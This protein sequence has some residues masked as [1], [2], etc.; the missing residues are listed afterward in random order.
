MKTVASGDYVKFCYKGMFTNG[1]VFDDQQDCEPIE[2]KV[3]S[4]ETIPGI[5]DAL[6]GMKP[7]EKKTLTLTPDQAYGVRDESLQ[8]TVLKSSLPFSFEPYEG[9][10]VAFKTPK[11]DQ[12]PAMVIRINNDEITLDFNH[13]LAGRSLI[14]ELEVAE[15]NEKPCGAPSRCSDG[16]G[17]C[18]S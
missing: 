6:I 4:G 8:R 9:Q 18:C 2:I 16:G 1:E 7:K 3:G 13:P 5:E 10:L 12:L 15:I 14:Y 11:G 17:C